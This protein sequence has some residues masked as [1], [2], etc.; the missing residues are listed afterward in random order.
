M[1]ALERIH[2]LPKGRISFTPARPSVYKSTSKIKG[3]K[4]ASAVHHQVSACQYGGKIG[5][6]YVRCW[7]FVVDPLEQWTKKD[8]DTHLAYSSGNVCLTDSPLQQQKKDGE[9]NGRSPPSPPPPP[10]SFSKSPAGL[11]FPLPLPTPLLICSPLSTCTSSFPPSTPLSDRHLLTFLPPLPPTF[12]CP[13]SSP[14]PSL[15]LPTLRGREGESKERAA[16]RYSPTGRGGRGRGR[17]R[18]PTTTATPTTFFPQ[19]IGC[20]ILLSALPAPPSSCPPFVLC[21]A[22]PPGK[23][24]REGGKEGWRRR[25]KIGGNTT[26]MILT[27]S[28]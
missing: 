26:K 7:H 1:C 13:L 27:R 16:P 6:L 25:R 28:V 24:L 2:K 18:R 5:G 14:L 23:L 22:P 20:Y 11:P 9:S 15:S 19:L 4:I 17:G 10:P 21:W 12:S 8:P 3:G